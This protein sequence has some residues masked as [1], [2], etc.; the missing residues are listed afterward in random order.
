MLYFPIPILFHCINTFGADLTE[1]LSRLS[2]NSVWSL[3]QINMDAPVLRVNS[4][5]AQVVIWLS[6][7]RRIS[8]KSQWLSFIQTTNN[9]VNSCKCLGC[10]NVF[11][12]L[13]VMLFQ[14][15]TR[16]CLQTLAGETACSDELQ[17]QAASAD[18]RD[19]L[20]LFIPK[21]SASPPN[22]CCMQIWLSHFYMR[23][24]FIHLKMFIL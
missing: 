6:E 14:G 3:P 21:I 7:N 20:S 22:K 9:A 13:P 15:T 10:V 18:S 24:Y 11:L 16:I 19:L 23:F 2:A 8:R 17:A 4:K 1:K 5:S 12:N